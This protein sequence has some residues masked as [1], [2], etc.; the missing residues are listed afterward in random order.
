MI[1]KIKSLIENGEEFTGWIICKQ[2]SKMYQNS[3]ESVP[4]KN[5][6]K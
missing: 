6:Q 5:G 1:D 3:P 4:V 2:S